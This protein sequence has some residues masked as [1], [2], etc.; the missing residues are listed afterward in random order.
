MRLKYLPSFVKR[1][2]RITKSQEKNLIHLDDYKIVSFDDILSA[3]SNFSKLVLEIGF[4]NGENTLNLAKANPENLYLASEVYIAGIG[5]LLGEI[6]KNDI[7]NIKLI[8]GDI[9][10]IIEDIKK[11]IFDDILIICPDPWPKLKHHKRRMINSEFLK[12]VHTT[13]RD[14]GHLFMSTDW[15]NYAESIEETIEDS[16]GY[17]RLSSSIYE[18]SQLTKFQKRAIEEGRKIYTF[19]LKKLVK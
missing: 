15:K 4:G 1:R 3:K 2:G 17:K 16:Y 8:S 13:I 7:K 14:N 9:R 11:P 18:K 10:L 6:I 19:S 5:Y 12:L